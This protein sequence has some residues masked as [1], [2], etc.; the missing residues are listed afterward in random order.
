MNEVLLD[1]YALQKDLRIK[2]PKQIVSNLH[3]DV[4]TVF[5][6]YIGTESGEII[7]RVSDESKNST[8]PFNKENTRY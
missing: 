3:V 1:S 5:D 8:A 4:G 6:I 2:L 7:L